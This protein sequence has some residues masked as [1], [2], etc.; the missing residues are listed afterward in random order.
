MSGNGRPR[1]VVTGIGVISPLGI[2][3]QDT[4]RRLVDGG[5]G[6]GEITLFDASEFE[7]RHACEADEFRPEDFLEHRAARRM[8]RFAQMA[9]AAATLAMADAGLSGDSDR[10]GAIVASGAGGGATREAQLAV[11]RDR[12]PDRVSP[13]AIPATVPNMAAAQVSMTLGARGPVTATCTACA[14]GTDAIGTAA[15]T[16]RRG[17]ADVMLAGGADTMITPLWVAGF[18]A[19]RVLTHPAE[20]PAASPRPFDV[21]RDGFL[22]GEAG[23]VLVLE[24]AEDAAARGARALVEVLGYGASADAHHMTDPDTT[25]EPQ[26]RAIRIALADAGLEPERVGYVNAHGGGSRVGDP[27]EVSALRRALGDDVTRDVPISATKAA[28]G[29]CMGAAGALEASIA[30][31][32]VIEDTLPATRNLAE[33]DPACAG[34]DHIM[35]PSRRADVGV[36]ISCSFGLGGHNSCLVLGTPEGR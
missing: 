28:H 14:A 15:A 23:A 13:L 1:I 6:A 33:V 12:G 24:R 18:D 11:M 29:H 2:G 5:S 30:A 26:S 27:A 4:W 25:G 10:L 7:V 21:G 34:I 20:D 17:A 22:V 3:I 19:M 8:D 35:G 31:M 36:A 32:A 9:V 16:L